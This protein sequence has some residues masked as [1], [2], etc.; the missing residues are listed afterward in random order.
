MNFKFYILIA[1]ERKLL[2]IFPENAGSSAMF[3]SLLTT[4]T[5]RNNFI[6]DH[7]YLFCLIS[8]PYVSQGK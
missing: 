1:L 5:L 3:I 7:F 2:F 4:N 6:Y 8:L